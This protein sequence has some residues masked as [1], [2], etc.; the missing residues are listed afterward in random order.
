MANDSAQLFLDYSGERFARELERVHLCLDQIY[1]SEVWWHP[2]EACNSIG[3]I[4]VHL[5]GNIGQWMTSV[6]NGRGDARD[7]HHEFVDQPDMTKVDVLTLL[8]NTVE[9]ALSTLSGINP[10]RLTETLVIQDF[11][12]S[13]LSAIYETE[14]HFAEHVGQIAYITK[15]RRGASFRP[16]WV[17]KTP[18]Q[19]A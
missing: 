17:P 3:N 15:M 2:G 6:A 16:L 1:E 11:D 13:I 14:R 10:A 4:I 19:G 5:C 9:Q 7:R 8:D 18:A 12:V